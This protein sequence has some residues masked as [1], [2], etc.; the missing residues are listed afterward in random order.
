M[1]KELLIR[2]YRG[3]SLNYVV[4]WYQLRPDQITVLC[5]EVEL[6]VRGNEQRLLNEIIKSHFSLFTFEGLVCRSYTGSL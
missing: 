4:L 2:K 6:P 1:S 5:P 3:K